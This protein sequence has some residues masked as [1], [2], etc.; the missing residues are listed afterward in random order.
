MGPVEVKY[1]PLRASGYCLLKWVFLG[2]KG[3]RVWT[4]KKP[5]AGDITAGI[6]WTVH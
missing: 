6:S 1:G 3:T 5:G 2:S 4:P